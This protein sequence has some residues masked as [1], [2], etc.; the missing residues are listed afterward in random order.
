MCGLILFT[1]LRKCWCN[2]S[3]WTYRYFI[4]LLLCSIRHV[5]NFCVEMPSGLEDTIIKVMNVDTTLYDLLFSVSSWPNIVLCLVGGIIIDRLLGLRKGLIIVVSTALLGQVIWALGAFTNQYYIMLVGRFFIGAGNDLTVIV[6]HA[7]KAL[8]FKDKLS[9]AMSIDTAFSRLGGA[10]ALI[11]PQLLYNVLNFIPSSLFRLGITLST[12]AI[13]LLGALIFSFAVIIMDRKGEKKSQRKKHRG[14][15]TIKLKNIRQFS[16]T[17]WLAV[18]VNIT[19]FPTVFSF[20]SIG[21]VFYVQ[22]YGLDIDVANIANSL[23]F[24][25]TIILTPLVGILIDKIGF[26]LLWLMAGILAALA[27]HLILIVSL[28]QVY[29]PFLAGVIYSISYT[30]AGP[31]FSPLPALLVEEDHIATAYG[32]FR[33]N[34]NLVFSILTV[35]TG[36]LVDHAGYFI[37]EIFYSLLICIAG[38]IVLTL[39]LRDATSDKPK[40]NI[41][42]WVRKET[43]KEREPS[44]IKDDSDESDDNEE[45]KELFSYWKLWNGKFWIKY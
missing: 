12:A 3:H 15:K 38:Y 43:F 2:P 6:S 10:L 42:G 33:S 21:Q 31:A 35:V 11:L 16:I 4:L 5:T 44:I 27:T 23:I 45:E 8:W 14:F 41:P 40:I 32:I 13:G 39:W 7:F 18:A 28:N 24:G 19:Y 20:V 25:A 22:K 37:L 30:L 9:F 17:Y 29:V 26:N 36:A 34:Y 1:W